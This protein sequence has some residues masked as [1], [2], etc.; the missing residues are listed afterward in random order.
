MISRS[1]PLAL[2]AALL[3]VAP[4]ALADS[5]DFT[6][7][8]GATAQCIA[9]GACACPTGPQMTCAGA[10]CTLFGD[11]V[12]NSGDITVRNGVT[13]RVTPW[14]NAAPTQ[15]ILNLKAP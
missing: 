5:L 11:V 8:G 3:A 15:G 7:N 2:A 4:S 1:F 6:L 12:C 13:L 10:T 9:T 14:T